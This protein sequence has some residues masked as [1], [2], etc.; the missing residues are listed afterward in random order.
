M[1]RRFV[2]SLSALLATAW[3]AFFAQATEAVEPGQRLQVS[4]DGEPVE[5]LVVGLRAPRHGSQVGTALMIGLHGYGMEASQISTLVQLEPS[6]DY[7]YIAPEGFHRL[8]DGSRAWFPIGWDGERITLDPADVDAFTRRF[9]AFVAAAGERFGADRVY[10]IGYSQG[11]AA[12]LHLATERPDL[13][14]AYAAFAGAVLLE[15]TLDREP[16]PKR[17]ES[18]LFI[19]HGTFDPLVS[20]EQMRIDVERLQKLGL[21]ID[22]REY[23]VPHVVGADQRRDVTEWLEQ[24]PR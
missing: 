11:G 14:A 20:T 2:L 21:D 19:G 6:F 8:E 24:L 16:D 12:A 13:A 10:V 18:R 7:V 15:S 1:I 9:A 3:G 23:P 17:L 4:A 5:A 22:Y